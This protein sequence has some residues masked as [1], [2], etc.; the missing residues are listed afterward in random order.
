MPEQG[1]M[2]GESQASCRLRGV[3]YYQSNAG[4]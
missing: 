2:L 3:L 1:N 4:A